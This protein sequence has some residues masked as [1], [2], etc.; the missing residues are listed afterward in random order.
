MAQ[1]DYPNC[2]DR[3][4]NGVDIWWNVLCNL[5]THGTCCDCN[6]DSGFL[7]ETTMAIASLKL[8]SEFLEILSI[9]LVR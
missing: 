5:K 7:V 2:K 1:V 9:K 4:G 3:M 8:I 6:E